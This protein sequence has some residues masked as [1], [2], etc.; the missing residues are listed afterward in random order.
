MKIP[1]TVLLIFSLFYFASSCK[2]GD[3]GSI[4]P[5]Y[6]STH[7]N[8]SV[9]HV[10]DSIAHLEDSMY[11]SMYGTYTTGVSYYTW[12]NGDIDGPKGFNSELEVTKLPGD[13]VRITVK[14]TVHYYPKY[15]WESEDFKTN[16]AGIYSIEV[17]SWPGLLYTAHIYNTGVTTIDVRDGDGDFY[18]VINIVGH[19]KK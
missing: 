12:V 10:T 1:V 11:K 5:P 18:T 16:S 19:K 9:K 2:K 15:Y 14:D 17:N 13:S 6:D 7:Y 3:T 4:V 8:D